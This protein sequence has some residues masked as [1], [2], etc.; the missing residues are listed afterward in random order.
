MRGRG[1]K[2][3]GTGRRMDW[4]QAA[5]RHTHTQRPEQIWFKIDCTNKH[6]YRAHLTTFITVREKLHQRG[7]RQEKHQ[8]SHFGTYCTAIFDTSSSSL[9]VILF[10]GRILYIFFQLY[11]N[12]A[13]ESMMYMYLCDFCYQRE[14]ID[15]PYM[16]LLS[17]YSL[18]Q[19]VDRKVWIRCALVNWCIYVVSACSAIRVLQG[20]TFASLGSPFLLNRPPLQFP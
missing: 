11:K 17:S 7:R 9:I 8:K 20:Q 18:I 15:I 14:I 16:S 4:P 2:R 10:N 13:G 6:H 1:E 3:A 5:C 19:C 12:C